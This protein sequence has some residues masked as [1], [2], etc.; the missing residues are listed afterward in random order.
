MANEAE[1]KPLGERLKALLAEYGMVAVAM[2]FGLAAIVFGGAFVALKLGFEIDGVAGGLGTGAGAYAILQLTKPVRI[3]VVL[4]ATP[5]V[6]RFLPK[7]AKSEAEPEP[8]AEEV[9]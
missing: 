4:A 7:R 3:V 6:A 5:V 2:W 1:K 9:A 8:E